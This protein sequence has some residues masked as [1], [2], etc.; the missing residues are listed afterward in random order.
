MEKQITALSELITYL[1]QKEEEYPYKKSGDRDS[2]SQHREGISDGLDW[3]ITKA[4]ELLV[5]EEAQIKR[6]YTFGYGDGQNS[7][8][9]EEYPPLEPAGPENYFSQTFETSKHL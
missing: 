2:Y 8:G 3:A 4:E 6:S 1:K 5:K 9:S 7:I